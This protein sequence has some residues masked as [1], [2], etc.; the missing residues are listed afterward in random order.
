MNNKKVSNTEKDVQRENSKLSLAE[1]EK[2][3]LETAS[4]IIEERD[5]EYKYRKELPTIWVWIVAAISIAYVAYHIYTSGFGMPMAYKHRV[6]HLGFVLSLVF[7]LFPAHE[8]SPKGRPSIIDIALALTVL[9]TTVY[10][11]RAIDMIALRAGVAVTADYVIGFIGILLVA[12]ACRRVIGYQLL[13]LAVAFILYA[14]FGRYMPGVFSHQG[15]TI[16][17]LIY[18]LYLTTQGIFGIPMGV[19][20]EYMVLFV[21]LASILAQ[22]GVGT[23]FNDV[24]LGLAGRSPG[25]PAKVAVIS[26]GLVGMIN[27][28]AA[29]NVATTGALTIPLMKRVGYKSHFAGAVEAAAS[30]GGQIMPPIMG[31]VAF[32]MSEFTGVPY[33]KIAAAAAIP[34]ILYFASVYF[35]VDFRAKKMGLTGLNEDEIPNYMLS[36]KRYSHMLLP[37]VLLVYL[38]MTQHSAMFSAFYALI[39]TIALSFL[40]KSTRVTFKEFYVIIIEAARSSLSVAVAMATAGIIV[41]I[42]A[43]TGIGLI[44][45]ENITLISGG[46]LFVVLILVMFVSI[47]LGMGLPTSACY[48]IAA[49]I[50]VSILRNVGVDMMQAHMFVLY[51][52]VLS[53]ITPPVALAAYVGAGIAGANPNKVGWTAF[54]LALAGFIIPFFFIY[55]PAM[56]LIADTKLQIVQAVITALVGV[57]LLAAG[58][59]GHFF[60]QANW[61]IRIILLA[62]AFTLIKPGIISDLVGLVLGAVAFGLV[63]GFKRP[64]KVAK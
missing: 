52:A 26:S 15:Y 50:C 38:L 21:F 32:I 18:Q 49:S 59:E 61:F 63:K 55:S 44:I 11:L 12:E 39:F 16:K 19:S 23:L 4:K 54:R 46:I 48:V 20:A 30:T 42:L 8:S 47:I 51:Y 14:Y 45:A 33:I 40:L 35:A 22:T 43:I 53:T 13:G 41:G 29:A 27:G 24:S 9:G 10:M 25:G 17:R 60:G 7:I 34:A 6:I 2:K 1:E 3:N 37:I 36:V 57:Y 62:A 56:L 31:T 28:G 58:S 5:R 64:V